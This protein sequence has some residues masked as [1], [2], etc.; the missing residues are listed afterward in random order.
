MM[1]AATLHHHH[2]PSSRVRE[3]PPRLRHRHHPCP[4]PPIPSS[5]YHHHHQQYQPT[6]SPPLYHFPQTTTTTTRP[7]TLP[8]LLPLSYTFQSPF[9]NL[10]YSP[11]ALFYRW[12]KP[13]GQYC[14]L[15]TDG[16]VNVAYHRSGFGGIIR[17]SR[18]API[19]GFAAMCPEMPIDVVEIIAIHR[20]L[21]IVLSN[22]V[23]Y[24]NIDTDS[25]DAVNYLFSLPSSCPSLV[26][27]CVLEIH[28]MLTHFK[29]WNCKHVFRETNR[30]ADY[31]SKFA[32]TNELVLDPLQFPFELSR[33]IDED[34]RGDL[35]LRLKSVGM[36]RSADFKEKASR[37][38]QTTCCNHETL[39]CESNGTEPTAKEGFASSKS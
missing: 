39:C 22:G 23:Q 9:H 29:S 24:I 2:P 14:T 12:A 34:A 1:H 16:S 17:D 3:V 26:R 38:L 37:K 7:T 32:G 4:S 33:I 13:I 11:E 25:S 10:N 6:C 36:S 8:P 28:T 30:A 35:Y 21:Q 31:L 27:N 18:G 19:V 20:G 5:Q 15:N